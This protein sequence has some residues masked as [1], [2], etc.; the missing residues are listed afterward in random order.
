[1]QIDVTTIRELEKEYGL[2]LYVFDESAFIE[3]YTHFTECFQSAYANYRVSYSYKTNYTP[4]VCKLIQQLGGFA[5]VVSGMEYHIAKEIGYQNDR[6]IF[7]GP[8]KG[9]DGVTAF[10]NGSIVN[11]D[12]IDELKKLCEAAESFPEKKFKC[13]LRVNLDVGQNFISRFGMDEKDIAAAFDL[14]STVPNLTISG[15]HCHISRCRGKEAWQ[16]R[17]EIMLALADKYFAKTPDY[18]DLGSGMF[19]NMAPSFKAQF[20][21]IPSYEEYASVTAQIVAEHYKDDEKKPILFTEPGTTL[22]NKYFDVIAKV[23][24]IKTIRGKAFAVLNCSEHNLGE[25]CT[26]KQLPLE[27]IHNIENHEE[28]TDVDFTGYTCL[29]QD[30]MYTGYNGKLTIGAYVVFGNTGGYSN[31]L[32]PPFIKPNCA[33]VAFT[34]DG[35]VKLIKRAETY[36]DL[37]HTYFF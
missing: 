23:D 21:N 35:E 32:K 2:P 12:H 31:V 22:I 28:Y 37:L 25:T 27:V 24:A 17:T 1:M 20:S 29:E 30:V 9:R 4:Y 36:D 13:G 11:V 6:I 7:N 5:E 16:K 34:V 18:I 14:V 3:N 33:M 10:L 26:L 15:L 19:G 8:D